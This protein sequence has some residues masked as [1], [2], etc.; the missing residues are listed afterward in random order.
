MRYA[1]VTDGVLGFQSPYKVAIVLEE[2][3]LAY[4]S[5]LLELSE[6]KQ[7]PFTDLNPN[8]RVPALTDPNTGLTI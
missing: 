4:E 5:R 1:K 8:G 6:V 2:L 7:K 3:G